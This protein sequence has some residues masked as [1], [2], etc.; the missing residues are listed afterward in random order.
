M[1][2]GTARNAMSARPAARQTAADVRARRL[3]VCLLESGLREIVALAMMMRIYISLL[4]PPVAGHSNA[5][6]K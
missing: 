2:N 6:V 5:C 1:A 3:R 4:G